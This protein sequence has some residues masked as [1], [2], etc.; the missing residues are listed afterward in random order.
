MALRDKITGAAAEHLRAGETV[1][2]V[3]PAVA[4]SPYWSLLSYWIVIAKDANRAI[5]ATDQRIIVFKTS[6][7][8][9]TKFKSVVRELPRTTLVGEPSGLNWKCDTLGETLWINKRFHNDIRAIDAAALGTTPP[10]S[11]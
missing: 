9:F 3:A 10:P 4:A 11:A 7:L 6:R 2:G 1:Q 5:V 8:R